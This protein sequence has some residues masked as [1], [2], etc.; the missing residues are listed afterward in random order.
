MTGCFES[1]HNL[2]YNTVRLYSSKEG[3]YSLNHFV[4][5]RSRIHNAVK[6]PLN[7][8]SC[9]DIMQALGFITNNRSKND[10]SWEASNLLL[11]PLTSSSK[12]LIGVACVQVD[13]SNVL[14]HER[15][16]KRGGG[17]GGVQKFQ[18]S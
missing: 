6:R 17:G 11:Y 15:A 18:W 8:K 4:I 5:S 13:E 10:R 9:H 12:T 1:K 16:R 2:F 3:R 14:H 7:T